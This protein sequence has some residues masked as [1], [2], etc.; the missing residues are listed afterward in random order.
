M[1]SAI[2]QLRGKREARKSQRTSELQRR[3]FEGFDTNIQSSLYTEGKN[4]SLDVTH[5][6]WPTISTDEAQEIRALYD[7]TQ[8]GLA[9]YFLYIWQ[10]SRYATTST[11]IVVQEYSLKRM[12]YFQPRISP[13]FNK[14]SQDDLE[15][16]DQERHQS[17]SG[18]II[19]W[20]TS[21]TDQLRELL[22]TSNMHFSTA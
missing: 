8:P 4:F 11:Q 14:A 15:N 21:S 19:A 20:L 9:M 1:N 2:F 12:N 13:H 10:Q 16:R 5:R 18:A 22:C 6:V 17:T 3:S 7:R